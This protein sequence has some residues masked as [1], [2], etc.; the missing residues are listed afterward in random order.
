MLVAGVDERGPAAAA[1][2]HRG[3][4]ISAV[5]NSSVESL[6][7]FYRKVWSCGPAGAEIPIEVVRDKRSAWLRIKSA[8]RSSFLKKPRLH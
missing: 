7:E 5:R 8:D 2:L 3:D 4:I 6:A 1:G